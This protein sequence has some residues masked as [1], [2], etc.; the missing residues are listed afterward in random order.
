MLPK[1]IVLEVEQLLAAGRLSQR[2]IARR[3]GLSRGSVALIAQGAWAGY[4]APLHADEEQPTRPAQRCP[5]CGGRVYLPC[6]LCAV[7]R[8]K[9]RERE[10]RARWQRA[11][12]AWRP[13]ADCRGPAVAAPAACG[14]GGDAAPT[15]RRPQAPVSHRPQPACSSA[16]RVL[17]STAEGAEIDS[18]TPPGPL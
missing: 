5:G 9:R 10:R 15:A 6:R 16:Q 4:S 3:L 12:A 11:L 18:A 2:Q 1:A 13:T 14:A 7:R 17:A 8:L